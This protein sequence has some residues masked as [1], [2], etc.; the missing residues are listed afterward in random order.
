[1]KKGPHVYIQT[2]KMLDKAVQ[3]SLTNDPEA[4]IAFRHRRDP[5][6]IGAVTFCFL[7]EPTRGSA[8]FS[9][10]L[11]STKDNFSKDIGRQIAFGRLT[12]DKTSYSLSDYVLE[13][14][15]M[16]QARNILVDSCEYDPLA[17]K[18]INEYGSLLY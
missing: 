11:C 12:L 7:V 1:M 8:K 3:W 17:R 4:F 13:E 2:D 14:D 5:Q 18:V 16:W 10:A 6:G 15:L 9:L